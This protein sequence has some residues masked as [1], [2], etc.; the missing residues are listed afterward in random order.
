MDETETYSGET[1]DRLQAEICALESDKVTLLL[2]L[3]SIDSSLS[4]LKARYGTVKNRTALIATLPSEIFAKIFELGRDLNTPAGEYFEIVVSQVT[5][6]WR[7]VAI[8]T[9][10]LWSML[11]I[12]PSRSSQ[13]FAMYVARAKACSLD[14]RFDFTQEVWVPDKSVWDVILPTVDRWR[15]LAISTGPNESALYTTL[16]HLEPFHVSLLEEI[17]ITRGSSNE[18]SAL[19][20]LR[21]RNSPTCFHGGAPRLAKLHLE[22]SYL[23]CNWP[24][25]TYLTTLYLHQHQLRRSA[26]PN[27]NRF[28]DLLT[29]SLRLSCL[30]IH[31]DVVSGK[32]PSH[33]EISM[34]HLRALRIR[35]TVLLGKRASDLLLTIS[36]PYLES[37]TLFDMVFSDLDPFL[38]AF[39][40]MHSLTSLT[41]YWPNFKTSTYVQLFET[42]PSITR[43]TL[44][45]RRPE[46]LLLLLG[47]PITGPSDFP[48]ARLE[49]F[50]LYP[51]NPRNGWIEDM[52]SNRAAN[53]RLRLLRLGS[54]SPVP[55]VR[56]LPFD[57]PSAWPAW[58]EE[59]LYTRKTGDSYFSA[60]PLRI[61]GCSE[62]PEIFMRF[63]CSIQALRLASQCL[64]TFSLTIKMPPELKSSAIERLIIM[65]SFPP[66]FSMLGPTN[67]KFLSR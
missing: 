61:S 45:D 47:N 4:R 58:P 18:V 44:M 36:A 12:A 63:I 55:G 37:L 10:P 48:W 1:L 46:E 11:E 24:P 30:S 5:S 16:A 65:S 31:G 2:K 60:F 41:L 26:R 43:L 21:F 51:G 42:M 38:S 6:E 39:Q 66:A 3:A 57:P 52:V 13:T 67:Q 49:D 14:L 9:P 29:S 23:S 34:P 15:S 59:G 33:F 56:V 62:I 22:G 53:G 28:R 40:L 17:T 20:P 50:A 25:L 27:W 64:E 19:G 8:N 35:G 54:E 7:E 32:P